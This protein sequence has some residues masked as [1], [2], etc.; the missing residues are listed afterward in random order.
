[1]FLTLG[2]GVWRR[3]TVFTH[4]LSQSRFQG[5]L[6]CSPVLPFAQWDVRLHVCFICFPASMIVCMLLVDDGH[7][8]GER[9]RVAC[10]TY[11]LH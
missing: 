8:D 10:Y 4:L 1:M 11:I 3:H 9:N 6:L 2:Y 5:L 7:G